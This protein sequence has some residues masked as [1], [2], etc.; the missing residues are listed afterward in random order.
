M[1]A[2]L[3]TRYLESLQN[4][5]S[6]SSEYPRQKSSPA[7]EAGRSHKAGIASLRPGNMPARSHSIR[8][9]RYSKPMQ[10]HS[11]EAP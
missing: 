4:V 2:I 7:A 1:I 11:F 10:I 8:S 9:S 6:L 3:R 5:Y